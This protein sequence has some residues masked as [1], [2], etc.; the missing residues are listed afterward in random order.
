M[1]TRI[2]KIDYH[3]NLMTSESNKKLNE[4]INNFNPNENGLRDH[5]IFGL[6]FLPEEAKLVLVPVPWEV[7]VSYLSGTS[8]GPEAILK[9]S[10]QID[11]YDDFH[12]EGWKE[13]I[14]MKDIPSPIFYKN[15]QIREMAEK[16]LFNYQNGK[17]DKKLQK[18]INQEC[19]NLNNHVKEET[20]DLIKQGKQVGI[21]GG[22]HSVILGFIE[23][24]AKKNKDFGILQIDAHSDTRPNYEDLKFS[25]AS[26]FYNILQLKEVSKIVQVGVRDISHIEKEIIN[27]G[28]FKNK[29]SLFSDYELKKSIFNGQSWSLKCDEIIKELPDNVYISFDI[30]GLNPSLCPNTGTPVPGGFSLEEISFLLEKI[31]LS[32]KK[33]IGFDLC[34][35]S[36]GENEWD[37]NVGARAL[38]KLC[39]ASLKSNS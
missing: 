28:E 17:I 32:G 10:Q 7:T 21:V 36:P 35:V 18:E 1:V 30:D 9:A 16:Y 15:K 20:A 26:I 11:L 25:H 14:A 8:K 29:I 23:V 13:G 3:R 4:K 27:K 34:E 38:Y 2:L 6:P 33:I 19:V 31:V 24:L 12:R 39:L 37:G 22:D 5:G